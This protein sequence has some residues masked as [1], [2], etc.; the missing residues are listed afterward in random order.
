MFLTVSSDQLEK[1]LS[2][3][4]KLKP[5]VGL[6]CSLAPFGGF[7]QCLEM[8]FTP[9]VSAPQTSLTFFFTV[10]RSIREFRAQRV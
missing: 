10:P 9:K 1:V 5:S 3:L 8:E 6:Q 2:L 7:K 4:P